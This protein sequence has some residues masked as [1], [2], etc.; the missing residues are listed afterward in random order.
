MVYLNDVVDL[1][2]CKMV[3]NGSLRIER[4]CLTVDLGGS[5]SNLFISI[6]GERVREQKL[7]K[8]LKIWYLLHLNDGEV[9]EEVRKQVEGLRFLFTGRTSQADLDYMGLILNDE[10]G[11][12]Q[13][14]KKFKHSANAEITPATSSCSHCDYYQYIVLPGTRG[15]IGSGYM[16]LPAHVL[17]AVA[18]GL[19]SGLSVEELYIAEVNHKDCNGLNNEL[20]NLELCSPSENMNHRAM[21]ARYKRLTGKSAKGRKVSAIGLPFYDDLDDSE[22]IKIFEE[23]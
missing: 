9:S 8:M 11:E 7:R 23:A 4:G 2:T 15:L 12:I 19:Y 14:I 21:F 18:G 13:K 17:Q 22:V 16:Q 20:S 5:P 1:E 6:T 3:L 10:T